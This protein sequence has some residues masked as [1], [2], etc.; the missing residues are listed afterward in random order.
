M[1]NHYQPVGPHP[2]YLQTSIKTSDICDVLSLDRHSPT[3]KVF[4]LVVRERVRHGAVRVQQLGR[5]LRTTHAPERVV[6]K[7]E[8]EFVG[9]EDGRL[10][11]F[12]HRLMQRQPAMVQTFFSRQSSPEMSP[13]YTRRFQCKISC[14]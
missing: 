1:R 8:L 10:A 12:D 7:E 3:S 6:V 13:Q 14:D 2:N 11:S 4:V 5:K 9:C